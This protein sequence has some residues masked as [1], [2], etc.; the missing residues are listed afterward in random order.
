MWRSPWKGQDVYQTS[1][2]ISREFITR[3]QDTTFIYLQAELIHTWCWCSHHHPTR[4]AHS[5]Q[6]TELQQASWVTWEINDKRTQASVFRGL[7]VSQAWSGKRLPKFKKQFIL[8]ALHS[9]S[10]HLTG[11]FSL[12]LSVCSVGPHGHF[13][14]C[15]CWAQS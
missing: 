9:N 6:G 2:V 3:S 5:I 12:A 1:P 11:N 10:S 8:L 4:M 14:L 13:A 7:H 15:M